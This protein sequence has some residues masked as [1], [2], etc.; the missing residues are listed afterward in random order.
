MYIDKINKFKLRLSL[1]LAIIV[2]MPVLFNIYAEEIRVDDKIQEQVINKTENN[3]A[4]AVLD[5]RQKLGKIIVAEEE[6]YQH[7]LDGYIRYMPSRGADAQSGKVGIIDLATEYSYTIKAFDQL[8]VELGLGVK[9]IDIT[10]TTAV[11]LPS[12]LTN[13]FIGAETTL[14]F[15]SFKN[16]YFT[17]ALAPEF[18][19]DNWVIRSSALLSGISLFIRPIIN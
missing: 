8:P 12:R 18:H 11:K 2:C 7:D 17:V 1:F 15:F 19:T 13:I 10:N 6:F 16:T 9:Y 14:P 3:S 5:Y 4:P